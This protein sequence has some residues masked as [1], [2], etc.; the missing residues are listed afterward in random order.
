[1]KGSLIRFFRNKVALALAGLTLAMGAWGVALIG[2]EVVGGN[3]SLVW[4]LINMLASLTPIL[5][6]AVVIEY[7]SRIA[8]A[9]E[10]P[11]ALGFE[12]EAGE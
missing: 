5:L 7:L 10:K 6:F 2:F 8:D 11:G 1:M 4:S 12:D 3:S 9:L